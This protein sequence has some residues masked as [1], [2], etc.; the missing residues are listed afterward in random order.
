MIIRNAWHAAGT[1]DLKDG[2]GG[3]N[4]AT[5]RFAPES[6]DSANA[7]LHI[8]RNV[9]GP[10]LAH[11]PKLST[12]DLWTYAGI[13]ALEFVGGPKIPHAFGRIDAPNGSTCPPNGRLPD[14]SQGAQHVRDIFYRMGFNDREIVALSG[15][16]TLGRCHLERSGYDGPWTR[17]PLKFDNTFFKNLLYL[18]WKPRKWDGPLQFED[19]ETGE[20]MM[21]PTD[22]V[23]RTDPQFRIY[24]E[25][26]AKDEALFF[27]DFGEAFAKLLHLGVQQAQSTPQTTEEKSCSEFREHCMHGSLE[28]VKK[29]APKVDVHAPE[30]TSGRTALHKASFWGHSKTV[31]FLLQNCRLNVNALDYN[32][33]TPLHDAVKLDHPATVEILLSAGADPTIRNLQGKTAIDLATELGRQNMLNL[34]KSKL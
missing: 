5:M 26:Y 10:V 9:L 20:L 14:A 23:L 30:P 25:M 6:T 2:S 21:L 17:H 12:A 22:M 3:S 31:S 1:Y 4:G 11:H 13:C 28:A 18:E 15:A 34:F 8:P 33:D 32:G 24:A 27:K 16:H 29:L 7:G 19:V